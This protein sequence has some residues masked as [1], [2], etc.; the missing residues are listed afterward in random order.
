MLVDKMNTAAATYYLGVNEPCFRRAVWDVRSAA[1]F[2]RSPASLGRGEA[3]SSLR[4]AEDKHFSPPTCSLLNFMDVA[5]VLNH[6]EL[7][8]AEGAEPCLA[9][10]NFLW[11]QTGVRSL[12]SP[13]LP[14]RMSSGHWSRLEALHL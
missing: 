6:E 3:L 13:N 7:R 2:R 14:P 12:R 11:D 8:E 10:A 4:H 5:W 9:S 1:P